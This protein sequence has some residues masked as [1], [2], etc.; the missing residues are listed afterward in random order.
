MNAASWGL[1][2]PEGD[3]CCARAVGHEQQT[4]YKGRVIGAR[5]DE[6]RD[7]E[8]SVEFSI[9]EY[10]DAAVTGTEFYLPHTFPSRE[11]AIEAVIQAGRQKIDVGFERGR[12]VANG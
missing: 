1:R 3:N 7:G 2:T 8:F 11:S 6:L 10:D 4:G 12:A 9:E 5:S